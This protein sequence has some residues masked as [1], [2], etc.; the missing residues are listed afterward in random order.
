MAG[1]EGAIHTYLM[2]ALV[3]ISDTAVSY[4]T[5]VLSVFANFRD[6]IP[7]DLSK[8]IKKR[9]PFGDNLEWVIERTMDLVIMYG[10]S[11][12][13][14]TYLPRISLS[15]DGTHRDVKAFYDPGHP[16]P[17]RLHRIVTQAVRSSST[18]LIPYLRE[19]K[20]TWFTDGMLHM[21]LQSFL[22]NEDMYN[23]TISGSDIQSAIRCGMRVGVKLDLTQHVGQAE[24]GLHLLHHLNRVDPEGNFYCLSYL[25]EDCWLPLLKHQ[26]LTSDEIGLGLETIRT[27]WPNVNRRFVKECELRIRELDLEARALDLSSS[28]SSNK[29]QKMSEDDVIVIAKELGKSGSITLVNQMTRDGTISLRDKKTFQH[30][31]TIAIVNGRSE[32]VNWICSEL[33]TL[34]LD[35]YIKSL[36]TNLSKRTDLSD[37]YIAHVRTVA[38][39]QNIKLT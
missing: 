5:Q 23:R 29:R 24:C 28:S 37:Q 20:T 39:D 21:A 6:H 30:L 15:Y 27:T 34:K 12:K 1:R 17:S 13:I 31:T 26:D 38:S 3:S 2:Y 32:L 18:E 36:I 14:M 25:Q 35:G 16:L 8:I 7:D 9:D 10:G 33:K 22:N 19:Q 4:P 11:R